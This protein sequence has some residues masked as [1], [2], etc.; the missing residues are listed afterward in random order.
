MELNSEKQKVMK[1]LQRNKNG[2]AKLQNNHAP[3][4]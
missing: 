4:L 2:W 1:E 3:T